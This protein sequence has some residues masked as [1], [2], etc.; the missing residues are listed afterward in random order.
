MSLGTNGF[1]NLVL[2]Q[3]AS[4]SALIQNIFQFF[5]FSDCPWVLS[6]CLWKQ[7]LTQWGVCEDLIW[8]EKGKNSHLLT[9]Y[10]LCIQYCTRSF[11][12]SFVCKQTF[13]S[14]GVILFPSLTSNSTKPMTLSQHSRSRLSTYNS[15]SCVSPAS[16]TKLEAFFEG[17]DNWCQLFL[18]P[19]R[20]RLISSAQYC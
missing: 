4:L 15:Y 2:K 19:L 16:H 6:F 8:E 11:L 18:L 9:T 12:C 13:C 17:K 20:A 7:F 3:K 10:L 5:F 1:L 14:V